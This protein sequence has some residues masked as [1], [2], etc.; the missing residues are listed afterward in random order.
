MKPIARHLKKNRIKR[1]EF[2]EALGITTQHLNNLCWRKG[3]KTPGPK[4]AAK[5]V[6]EFAKRGIMV[7]IEELLFPENYMD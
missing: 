1:R 7:T 6:Q 4:L 2:A 5:M 3:V